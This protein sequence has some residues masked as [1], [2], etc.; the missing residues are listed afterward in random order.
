MAKLT[1]EQVL[2]AINMLSEKSPNRTYLIHPEWRKDLAEIL[3]CDIDE[4]PKYWQYTE[5]I[6]G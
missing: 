3:E 2:K 4:I 5:K 6:N 1:V